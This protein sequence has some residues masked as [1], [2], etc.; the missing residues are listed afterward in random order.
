VAQFSAKS[1]RADTGTAGPMGWQAATSDS[2]T[3]I[4]LPKFAGDFLPISPSI[5]SGAS[6]HRNRPAAL[7]W[8]SE[9]GRLR[10]A[11]IYGTKA[12]GVP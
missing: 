1:A 4:T 6:Q 5:R 11:V 3:A 2:S 7:I 12:N 8:I 9:P 10:Q